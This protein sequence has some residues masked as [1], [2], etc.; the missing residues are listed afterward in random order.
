M[1]R[2]GFFPGRTRR[3]TVRSVATTNCSAIGPRDAEAQN[4]RNS[5]G[6][7]C[8]RGI[9]PTDSAKL[10]WEVPTIIDVP[11]I[12]D[13]RG[14]V[15]VVERDIPFPFEIKRVYYLFDVPS[16]AVRGSHAHKSL[17][18]L[19]IA[20]SGSFSVGLHDGTTKS[21]FLLSS[22]DKGLAVPPGYWRTLNDFSAGSAVLVFASAEY[23]PED[24]IR[25]FAEFQTW[26]T[27]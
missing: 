2:R 25:D 15:G 12:R 9:G 7:A 11:V 8:L 21:E 24:Y 13:D 27:S 1:N 3:A 22:P 16:N 23:D 14:A 5:D 6:P 10:R 17:N 19:I 26:V 4:H 20:I 18:Q